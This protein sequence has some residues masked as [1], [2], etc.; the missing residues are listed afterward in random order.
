MHSNID[1]EQFLLGAM[2]LKPSLVDKLDYEIGIKAEHFYDPIHGHIF[3]LIH[4]QATS[5]KQVDPTIIEG[6][7]AKSA[8]EKLIEEVGQGYV[9]ELAQNTISTRAAPDYAKQIKDCW[10]RNQ[11]EAIG[12]QLA[13]SGDES[14]ES[15]L[16]DLNA[17]LTDLQGGNVKTDQVITFENAL[18]ANLKHAERVFQGNGYDDVTET[19]FA[20]LD[21]II[22]GFRKGKVYVV[23]GRPAMGKTTLALNMAYRQVLSGVPVLFLSL[24]MDH[25][26]LVHKIILA[27]TEIDGNR[28]DNNDLTSEEWQRYFEK[29]KELMAHKDNLII[30]CAGGITSDHARAVIMKYKREKGIKAVYIDYLQIMRSPRSRGRYEIVT[31]LSN[32]LM[33]IAKTTD[34]PIVLLSQL[35]RN[36]EQREDKRPTMADLRESGAIEQDAYAIMFVYRDE[37]YTSREQPQQRDGESYEKFLERDAVWQERMEQNKGIAEIIVAKNRGGKLGTAR[38]RFQGEYSKFSDL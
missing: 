24:E 7:L 35:S 22:R 3:E 29:N 28:F 30:D 33:E 19:R 12:T 38:A 9:M 6:M 21:A 26:E 37:Y 14:L 34:V 27:E 16:S 5:G 1:A 17:Q 36:L 18:N 31:D 11:L 8:K 32:D 2:V 20:D 4:K 15:I 10:T 23:A 25:S 13:H